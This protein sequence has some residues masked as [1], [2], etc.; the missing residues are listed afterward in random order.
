MICSEIGIISFFRIRRILYVRW[1]RIGVVIWWPSIRND[2]YLWWC[3]WSAEII[4]IITV[5]ASGFTFFF[6]H[7]SYADC[8]SI[9][10]TSSTSSSRRCSTQIDDKRGSCTMSY[11][12]GHDKLIC[13]VGAYRIS[14][15]ERI[16]IDGGSYSSMIIRKCD[17][18]SG[19]I[20]YAI[21]YSGKSRP[22]IINPIDRS[23]ILHKGPGI[24]AGI[25]CSCSEWPSPSPEIERVYSVMIDSGD[26]RFDSVSSDFD[27]HGTAGIHS[28]DIRRGIGY[29]I[30][31]R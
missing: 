17:G 1:C 21:R 18:Y 30:R 10:S 22:D 19:V 8:W 23:C 29:I 7:F 27:I 16:P 9:S 14:I 31:W 4:I 3:T 15:S 5:T 13:S 28:G 2:W 12:I 20:G 11:S 6:Y 26:I 25:S 24:S